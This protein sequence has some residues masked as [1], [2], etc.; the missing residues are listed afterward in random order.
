MS[1]SI[2]HLTGRDHRKLQRTLNE[3]I[4]NQNRSY[5]EPQAHQRVKDM[6]NELA[7]VQIVND[8]GPQPRVRKGMKLWRSPPD[9]M[10]ASCLS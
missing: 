2:H 4:L 9:A 5:A 3:Y 6:Y 1:S 7:I 10:G 8:I